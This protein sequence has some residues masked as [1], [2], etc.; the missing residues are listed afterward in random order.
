MYINTIT[1]RMQATRS[2]SAS[3]LPVFS[4]KDL[5]QSLQILFIHHNLYA[6]DIVIMCWCYNRL[7][8]STTVILSHVLIE[9]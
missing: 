1:V 8:Q 6:M 3:V 2:A 9:S 4:P 5:A 7:D